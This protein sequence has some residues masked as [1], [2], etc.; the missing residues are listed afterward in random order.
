[1]KLNRHQHTDLEARVVAQ[2]TLL[3]LAVFGLVVLASVR[4]LLG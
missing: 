1:V 3:L 2:A 4:S